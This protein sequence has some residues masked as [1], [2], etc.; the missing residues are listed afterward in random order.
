MRVSS[1]G[2]ISEM[3]ARLSALDVA[4]RVA[5]G[6][7]LW[8]RRHLVCALLVPAPKFSAC[9]LSFGLCILTV[10]FAPADSVMRDAI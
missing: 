10:R 5:C 3:R 9:D 1:V 4:I 7:E 2:A 8:D 6:L